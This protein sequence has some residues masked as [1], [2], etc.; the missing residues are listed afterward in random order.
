MSLLD[1]ATAG[2]G[3]ARWQRALV[4]LC[5]VAG[6]AGGAGVY[7]GMRW[8]R[9][10]QAIADNVKLHGDL[11][12]LEQQ[13]TKLHDNAEALRQAGIDIAQD[14]RTAA[15]RM[16]VISQDYEDERAANG[17]FYSEQRRRLQALGADRPE[18]RDLRLG[19]GVLEHWNQSNAGARSDAAAPAAAVDPDKPA[20][21]VPDATGSAQR[22]GDGSAGQPRPGDRAVPKLR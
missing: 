5:V 10:T 1:K 18:L 3:V 6:I 15:K 2:L 13:A 4:M 7:L 17:N 8:E 22:P 12:A 20:A 14:F 11:A 21:A 19:D 9:G 16:D